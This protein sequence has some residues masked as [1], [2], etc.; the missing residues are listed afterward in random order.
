MAGKKALQDRMALAL[1]KRFGEDSATRLG[2]GRTAG[3]QPKEMLTSGVDVIDHYLVGRG[4]FPVGRITEVYGPENCGKTTLMY[5][6]LAVN[7]RRGAVGVVIDA[8]HAFD[9]TRAAEM[10]VPIDDLIVQTPHSLEEAFE[11]IKATIDLHDP[12]AGPLLLGWDAI[13]SSSPKRA[14]ERDLMNAKQKKTPG[15]F[16]ALTSEQFPIVLRELG[17]K[18]AHLLCLNQTRINIGVMFG[19]PVTTPG[20]SAP[21]FFST[22]RL[23]MMGG[24]PFK[25]ASNAH[26]GKA[27]LVKAI[28]T[29]FVPPFRSARVKIDYAKG[30][31]NDWT[32]LEWAKTLGLIPGQAKGKDALEKARA[33]LLAFNTGTVV[34]VA[35][36]SAPDDPEEDEALPAGDDD[37][38][39]LAGLDDEE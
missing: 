11:M 13:A 21:K 16:A 32:T 39:D 24:K 8:D 28:K 38:A 22:N 5:H 27:I 3:A 7:M 25:D 10:G 19:D 6:A 34:P 18:R 36:P 4:G 30:Y 37:E 33:A 26:T 2:K 29:R 35:A 31:D 17:R 20:G 1:Q 23:Q 9:E 12:S 15:V 14:A